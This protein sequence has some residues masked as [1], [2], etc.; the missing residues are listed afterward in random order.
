M[1]PPIV[2]VW[3]AWHHDGVMST[4]PTRPDLSALVRPR[5]SARDQRIAGIA[6]GWA[7]QLG[8]PAQAVRAVLI[9]LTAAGGLGA[10]VYVV[11]WI[12]ALDR[13]PA[14][15][16]GPATVHQ[17]VGLGLLVVATLL[18]MR[19]VGLWFGD[20]VAIPAVLLVIG[21]AAVWDRDRGIRGWG[22]SAE[23]P[24]P[25]QVIVGVGLVV[26][27]VIVFTRLGSTRIGEAAGLIIGLL[28]V[29]AGFVLVFGRLVYRLANDLTSE[30][31]ARVRQEERAEVAA[32][33][34]D[35]VLQ[36]FALIQR[37]DD[38]R[39]MV[40]LARR[41]ERELREW[42]YTPGATSASSLVGGLRL[43]A[44]RVEDV[45]DVPVEVVAVG[46]VSLDDHVAALVAAAGEAM[47][48]AAKHSGAD[49]VSVYAEVGESGVEVFVNDLGSGFDPEGDRGDRRGIV[50]SIRGRMTRHGGEARITSEPGEG[51]EV[52]LRLPLDAR[53]GAAR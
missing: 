14:E 53:N 25:T 42:L 41:Q 23:R 12:L 51:T 16:A 18:L 2:G 38:P 48:N 8:V 43:A 33:L 20:A 11:A 28:I 1:E 47:T 45:H 40:T 4:A 32:H 21:V 15:P 30:R 7:E 10:I 26:V 9:A 27:G 3:V 17:K 46:D 52:A 13:P 22:I 34:H 29:G 31:Y 5:R 24:R 37:T 39:R 50:D 19:A 36:T 35:S 6:A 44:D 49:R